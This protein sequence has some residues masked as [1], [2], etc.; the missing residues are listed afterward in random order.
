LETSIAA[1][2]GVGHGIGVGNAT[3]ALEI[4]MAAKGI[5]PGDEVIFPSHTMVASPGS[6]VAVGATPVPVDCGMNVR[7]DLGLGPDERI[8]LYAGTIGL[9][10][11]LV[12]V[13]NAAALLGAS[14]RV[15]FVLLGDGLQLGPLKQLAAAQAN[16]NVHFLGRIPGRQVAG[17]LAQADALLLHLRPDPLFAV[18][19]PHKLY[20]YMAAA[21]PVLVAAEGDAAEIVLSCGCGI[22]CAPGDPAD[23]ARAASVV[24]SMPGSALAAMGQRGAAAAGTTYSRDRFR[25]ELS[26]LVEA[27]AASPSPG[28]SDG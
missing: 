10:Q 25:S 20:E 28:A 21:K 18:T 15:H 14:S 6:V 23:I 5:G 4:L 26:A 13:V 11:D 3:D 22:P 8:I 17:V 9:A 24:A 19:I 12:A 2:L 27:A 16:A 7:R 1:Y